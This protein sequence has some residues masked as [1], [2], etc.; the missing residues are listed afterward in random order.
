MKKITFLLLFVCGFTAWS[1]A[2]AFNFAQASSP[3]QQVISLHLGYAHSFQA[4]LGYA[5]E[6][7]AGKPLLLGGEIALPAGNSLNDWQGNLGGQAD[8]LQ[9]GDFHLVGKAYAVLRKWKMDYVSAWSWGTDLALVGGFY[10]KQG[11]LA[12][13]IGYDRSWFTNLQHGKAHLENYPNAVSGWYQSK[14]GSLYFGLQGG[15]SW[16]H[17]DLN[18]RVARTFRPNGRANLIPFQALIGLN[19]RW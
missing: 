19:Y 2:Q 17:I 10:R 5:R 3:E 8:C 15:Y 9:W 14:A 1:W 7:V 12:T 6:F 13:E 11:F 4:R 18:L 16:S